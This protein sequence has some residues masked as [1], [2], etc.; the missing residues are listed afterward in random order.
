MR[1]P[2]LVLLATL[3]LSGCEQLSV[4]SPPSGEVIACDAALVG[5]WE[6]FG[7]RP[8][9]GDP[10][11]SMYLHVDA[12]CAAWTSI[13][14]DTQRG[15]NVVGQLDD[16][17]I[18]TRAVGDKRYI[19]VSDRDKTAAGKHEIG[20]GYVLYRYIAHRDRVD[21]FEGD[22]RREAHR[23]AEGLVNGRV[24]AKSHADCGD[25][26]KCSVN[27]MITGDGDAIAAWLK[28]FDPLDS[29]VME[30]RRIDRKTEKQLERHLKSPAP[31]GKP[32]PHE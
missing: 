30:L 10:D 17:A 18:E 8:D 22:P 19:V 14:V 26:G 27:T 24:E 23:I 31:T 32:K 29:A 20:D 2:V 25:D 3:V 4:Q 13:E 15:K 6:M 21:L 9:A 7:E 11:E 28:R 12:T 5:W 16:L 1:N